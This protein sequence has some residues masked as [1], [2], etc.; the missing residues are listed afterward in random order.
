MSADTQARPASQ[1]DKRV[2]R[3]QR[4]RRVR[5]P[6][7][8]RLRPPGRRRRHRSAG[9]ALGNWPPQWTTAT[10]DAVQGLRA[11]GYSWADIAARL[12]VSRQAAQMRWGAHPTDCGR[13]DPRLLNDG[14]G[15]TVAQLVAVFADHHP[16][17]P[18]GFSLPGLRLPLS[19]RG[20]RLP[21][22]H[23]RSAAALPAPPRRPPAP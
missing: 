12:G 9:R 18:A 22:Q 6:D 8:A 23:R 21:H 15:V 3:E 1:R 4:V 16:G 2:V 5:A 7:R 10:A 13:L 19:A 17:T 14:L 20:H 11:F